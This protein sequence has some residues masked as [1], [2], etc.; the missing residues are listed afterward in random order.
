MMAKELFSCLE[1][2][3][4]IFRN[5]SSYSNIG[6]FQAFCSQGLSQVPH[7]NLAYPTKIGK[8]IPESDEFKKLKSYYESNETPGNLVV[9]D[10]Q[11]I[12]PI[13]AEESEYFSISDLPSLDV[14]SQVNVMT[15]VESE[16]DQFCNLIQLCFSLEERMTL[17]F[18]SKMAMLQ[19]RE[20]TKFY[21]IKVKDKIVGGCSVFGTDNGSS[22]MFNVATHPSQQGNGVARDVIGY[23]AK[24]SPKPLYTYSHN[25]IMR[26]S[27]LPRLG[28]RSIGTV[29]CVPLN[30]VKVGKV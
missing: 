8:E 21:I 15:H 14:S 20:G 23:A 18:K 19:N 25:P 10:K 29:W 11:N 6:D 22:F 17:Y 3:R 26:E 28:F 12:G 13:F 7:W 30:V 16:L 5:F 9:T 1:Q 2:E 4:S 24:M 27:I